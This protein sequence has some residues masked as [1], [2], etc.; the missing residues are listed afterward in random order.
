[1]TI[2][3]EKDL[4]YVKKRLFHLSSCVEESL[5]KAVQAVDNRDVELAGLVISSDVEID[6]LE[7]GLEEECLK[8]LALHQPVAIDL[9]FI[10]ALLKINN[11]LER[12]GDLCVNIAERAIYLAEKEDVPFPFD[13][14]KMEQ[15]VK[16]M[17]RKSINAMINMKE[18]EAAEVCEM[19]D[20][21]DAINREMYYHVKQMVKKNA[22]YTGRLLHMLCISRHLE[23]IADLATNIAEDVIYMISGK[24][25]RHQAEDY[26]E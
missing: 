16:E 5:A 9:R 20:A 7:V 24:I 18:T 17:V 2:H 8:L 1:M 6:D 13:F 25:I 26:R 21:V 12:I 11:D 22:D 23:R 15:K 3:F 10:V 19:D 4:Q 14:S